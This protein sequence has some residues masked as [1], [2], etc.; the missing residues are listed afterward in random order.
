M[1][2]RIVRH[3]IIVAS[4]LALGCTSLHLAAPAHNGAKTPAE[5]IDEM[6]ALSG[7]DTQIA[8]IPAAIQSKFTQHQQQTRN[9]LSPEHRDR[10][11]HILTEA[12]NP[13]DFRQSVVD[14]FAAHYERDHVR[15]E[16]QILH[17]PLSQKLVKLDEQASTP[18]ALQ[19][20]K[21]I[22]RTL[23]S[24]PPSPERMA[25]IRTFDRVSGSTDLGV[26]LFVSTTMTVV[27][28][29]N[30]ASPPGKRLTQD[31]LDELSE[32]L[33]REV[34]HPVERLT[35]ATLLYMFRA[36][37]DAEIE[38]SITLYENDTSEWFNQVVK[39]A[40]ISAMVTATEKAGREIAVMS[41]EQTT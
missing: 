19:E 32:Q 10:L 1:R 6:L 29:F 17:S 21:S 37:P 24:S 39:A 5:E 18:E 22:A 2:R 36:V 20:I 4:V 15:A 7:L 28:S 34:Q 9:T 26:E 8:L 11:L 14:Y 25:L 35:T 12:Y 16:L 23:E 30:A 40:L 38:H 3:S 13:S 27:K 33:R 31:Q 41:S